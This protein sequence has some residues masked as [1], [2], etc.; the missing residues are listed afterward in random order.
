MLCAKS[1]G[2]E[3][4]GVRD[5]LP[6]S[7]TVP[8]WT[9]W[10]SAPGPGGGDRGLGSGGSR[11]AVF[12][13]VGSW[14]GTRCPPADPGLGPARACQGFLSGQRARLSRRAQSCALPEGLRAPGRASPPA[15]V[16]ALGDRL[17]P[18]VRLRDALQAGPGVCET[19]AHGF[20]PQEAKRTQA[21]GNVNHLTV[22]TVCFPNTG[23]VSVP[24]WRGL[25]AGGAA[26]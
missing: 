18:P 24:E 19:N 22:F 10:P 20:G 23:D 14:R 21:T 13:H 5:G 16:T 4:E 6:P 12:L 26:P 2:T 25:G 3:D 17:R 8:L 9:A 1:K 15:V 7:A 11:V